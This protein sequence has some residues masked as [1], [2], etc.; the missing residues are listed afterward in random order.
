MS[1]QETVIIGVNSFLEA[2]ESLEI[3]AKNIEVYGTLSV[4]HP[5]SLEIFYH[6]DT[7]RKLEGGFSAEIPASKEGAFIVIRGSRTS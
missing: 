5:E 2:G 6:D 4:G 3:Y 1:G 7:L